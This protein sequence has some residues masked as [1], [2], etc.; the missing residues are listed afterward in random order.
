MHGDG[1]HLCLRN[2]SRR[3]EPYHQSGCRIVIEGLVSGEV[4]LS[5]M[6]AFPEEEGSVADLG[7]KLGIFRN[8]DASIYCNGL[9]LT[10]F[11]AW[12]KGLGCD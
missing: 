9:L 7:L 1:L 5:A 8:V 10:A 12:C 6:R 4:H 3:N 11:A 2:L